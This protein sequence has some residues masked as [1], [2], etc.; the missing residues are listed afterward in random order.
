QRNDH[1][2]SD[3]HY[4]PFQQ[5][6]PKKSRNKTVPT[7][8]HGD[9]VAQLNDQQSNVAYWPIPLKKSAHDRV[10]KIGGKPTVSQ[11][12]VGCGIGIS[13]A[14]FRRFWAVAAR[15]NSSWAP[16]GPRSRSRSSLRM[17]LR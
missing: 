15:R 7:R 9:L 17:R 6:R 13:L 11:V 14:S 2:P 3:R 10:P 8:K 16:F 4:E 12:G 5:W 1:G